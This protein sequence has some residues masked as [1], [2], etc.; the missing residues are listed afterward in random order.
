[1]AGSFSRVLLWLTPVLHTHTTLYS[2]PRVQNSCDETTQWRAPAWWRSHGMCT[3]LNHI[4]SLLAGKK[5]KV[6]KKSF[7]NWPFLNMH[8]NKNL[9]LQTPLLG[10]SGMRRG[11]SGTQ[12][13]K[14]DRS[15][16]RSVATDKLTCELR[17]SLIPLSFLFFL[18]LQR[19]TVQSK[20]MKCHDF[21][22]TEKC[23]FIFMLFSICPQPLL[24]ATI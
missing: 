3:I 21:F 11:K 5:K 22:M 1:M 7:S 18:W 16:S 13:K 12:R 10:E 17:S 2:S 9:M 4:S 15:W 24:W 8:F 19:H 6:E 14:K 23:F 20:R